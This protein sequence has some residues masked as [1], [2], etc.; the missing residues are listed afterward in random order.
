MSPSQRFNEDK[1]L[2]LELLPE[3][4]L[5]QQFKIDPPVTDEITAGLVG[6]V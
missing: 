6:F 5:L 3:F 4:A 1:N 2:L